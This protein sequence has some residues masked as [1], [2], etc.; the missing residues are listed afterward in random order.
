MLD[1]RPHGKREYFKSIGEARTRADQ[2][3]AEREN[4]GTEALSFSTENRVMAVECSAKLR[5]FGKTLRDATNHYVHWLTSEE[6]KRQSLLVS[7]CVDRFIESR[8]AD[9]ERGE[10]DK[11]SFYETRD[12]A[13]QVKEA[14][15]GL[16]IGE[17]D[18][19][20]VKTY[21]DY[22]PVTPRTRNKIR[23]RMSKYLNFCKEK[24]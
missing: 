22:F 23:M 21:L 7:E 14:L 3:A 1:A 2:L 18:A 16:H 9:M 24:K 10:L 6:K 15:G 12:R 20:R 17:I 4:R 5:P 19:E 8:R 13:K 11:K